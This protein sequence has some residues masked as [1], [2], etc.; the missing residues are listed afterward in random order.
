MVGWIGIDGAKPVIREGLLLSHRS[1]RAALA[2]SLSACHPGN[3]G[4]VC[5]LHDSVG[6][7]TSAPLIRVR[8]AGLHAATASSNWSGYGIAGTFSAVT[9]SWIVP[10]AAPST[11]PTYSSSW[12]GIDGLANRNLIQA[13]TESDYVN[14]HAQYD[15]WWEVLPG[16]EKI[17]AT[18]PV[19][20]GDHL[21]ASI[22]RTV[23][24]KPTAK[25]WTVI[26]FDST[27]GRSFTYTRS[28]RGPA[29]SA[30]W[31]EE[32]PMVGRSLSALA[33]YWLDDVFVAHRQRNQSTSVRDGGDLHGRRR[34]EPAD[35]G[36]IGAVRA[37]RRLLGGLRGEH[38]SSAGRMKGSASGSP[39]QSRTT[40]RFDQVRQA[41]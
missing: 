25:K 26:L 11:G 15:A 13:G 24:K 19:A 1:I 16:A 36:A 10:A 40:L 31:I 23:A 4:P 37:A 27:S 8:D 9:G 14:G 34:R 6:A 2:A 28:Y 17:V 29:A 35:L 38:P 41:T 39:A 21:S 33:N 5:R 22:Y 20:P 32:R 7:T 12:I 18:L 3:S 30:E